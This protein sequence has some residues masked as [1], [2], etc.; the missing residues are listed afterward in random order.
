VLRSRGKQCALLKSRNERASFKWPAICARPYLCEHVVALRVSGVI[1]VQLEV[2]GRAP[3]QDGDAEALAGYSCVTTETRCERSGG[4]E[5][6][7]ETRHE[8]G[9]VRD[10]RR[11]T[12]DERRRRLCTE[13][14]PVRRLLR[15]SCDE[16]SQ[17]E[18][19][20]RARDE[21]RDEMS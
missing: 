3:P 5:T 14:G 10:E 19:E 6:R 18:S 7:R 17:E 11:V 2:H 16:R 1:H 21:T 13:V 8:T 9:D 15:E 4:R 20:R 12:C